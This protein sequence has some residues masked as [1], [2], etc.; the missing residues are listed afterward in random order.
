[1]ENENEIVIETEIVICEANEK[2]SETANGNENE[3]PQFPLL[4]GKVNVLAI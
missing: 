1:M 2:G 3:I 4:V